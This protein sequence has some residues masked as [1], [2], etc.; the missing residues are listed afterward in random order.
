MGEGT[1]QTVYRDL[2]RPGG[3]RRGTE[4]RGSRT[5]GR[6]AARTGCPE[7]TADLVMHMHARGV[8]TKP[9]DLNAR[10]HVEIITCCVA[11]GAAN[12]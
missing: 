1:E 10:H 5:T 4:G 3:D 8:E 2:R 9:L 12:V 7:L 6:E 11:C